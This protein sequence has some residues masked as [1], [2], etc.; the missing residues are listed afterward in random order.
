MLP[1]TEE[2]CTNLGLTTALEPPSTN[3]LVH[4]LL[5]RVQPEEGVGV[6][7]TPFRRQENDVKLRKS[8]ML[9]TTRRYRRRRLDA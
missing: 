7:A 3:A 6:S 8:G 5:G 1:S 2:A 4:A 9:M